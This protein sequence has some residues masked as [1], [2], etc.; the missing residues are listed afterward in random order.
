MDY[1]EVFYIIIN[2]WAFFLTDILLKVTD[3][4]FNFVK[5]K[6][7]ILYDFNFFKLLRFIL[8]PIL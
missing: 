8:W 1:L 2:I 5:F 6:E 4:Q 3:F 7:Y